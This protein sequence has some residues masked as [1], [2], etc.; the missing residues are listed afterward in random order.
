[1]YKQHSL[2]TFFHKREPFMR[3]A[4]ENDF[5]GSGQR[6]PLDDSVLIKLFNQHSK[7]I[8]FIQSKLNVKRTLLNHLAYQKN[9]E[10]SLV[11]NRYDIEKKVRTRVLLIDASYS[12]RQHKEKIQALLK[13]ERYD[14]ILYHDRDIFRYEID[15]F[16]IPNFKG[17]TS[18][19]KPLSRLMDI[20]VPLTIQ[21]VTDGEIALY[22]EAKARTILKQLSMV[23][24][25]RIVL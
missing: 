12:M 10:E 7:S 9:L 8:Q 11:Y 18:Y 13:N 21:H 16:T 23:L 2:P 19:T 3:K 17:G 1:M 22:D 4:N 25:K 24:Y 20:K 14:I 6:P 5:F 15:T